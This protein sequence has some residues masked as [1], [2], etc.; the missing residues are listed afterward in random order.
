M[1]EAQASDRP[2]RRDSVIVGELDHS[3]VIEVESALLRLN[4]TAF[5][6]WQLCDGDTTLDEMVAA[7]CDLF[8]IDPAEAAHDVR[9]TIREMRTTGL[10]T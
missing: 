1:N 10:V 5:A 9:N 4:P 7:I 6:L 3:M 8:D 2:R